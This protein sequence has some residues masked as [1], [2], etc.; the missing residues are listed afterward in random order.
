MPSDVVPGA[1]IAAW[2]AVK[3]LV[4]LGAVVLALTLLPA[5]AIQV[6]GALRVGNQ[7]LPAASCATRDTLWIHHY[8]AALYVPPKTAPAAALQDPKQPKALHI[9]VL[10][11]SLLPK[12][13]PVK[14]RDTLEAHLDLPS[15]TSV[16]LAW[17]EI[18]VGDRVTI[19]YVPGSGVTLQLND[20]VVARTTRH[21]VVDALLQTWAENEPISERVNRVIARNPCRQ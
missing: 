6:P 11:R 18:A 7:S 12:D 2:S 19:A 9:Q 4:A 5:T 10:S 8:A 3:W 21:E 15:Y 14:W 17:R 1:E 20:R 16:R 13:L